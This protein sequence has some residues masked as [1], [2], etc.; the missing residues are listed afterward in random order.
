MRPLLRLALGG[1]MTWIASDAMAA[2]L[3]QHYD[4]YRDMHTKTQYV[5]IFFNEG[6]SN[7]VDF[8]RLGDIPIVDWPEFR[9]FRFRQWHVSGDY[10]LTF[11]TNVLSH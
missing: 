8:D 9:G 2:E 10:L 4:S 7:I 11:S 6:V 3:G 1:A 5:S